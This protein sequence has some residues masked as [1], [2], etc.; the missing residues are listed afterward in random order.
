M[1]KL[2]VMFKLFGMSHWLLML[3]AIV[4]A[5]VLVFVMRSYNGTKIKTTGWILVGVMLLL[6]VL[7][8]VGRL[9][10]GGDLFESLPLEPINVFVFLCLFVQIKNNLTWIKFGYFISLPVSALGL[11]IVPNYLTSMGAWSL[12]GIAYFLNIGVLAGYV[13]LQLLWSEEYLSKKDILNCFVNYIIIISFIHILNVIF[14]FTTLGVHVNYM[15]TM[16][17]EYDVFNKWLYSIIK[18]PFLHQL[19]IW[20]I[21]FGLGFLLNIPFDIFKTNKDRQAQMEELVALGNLKAQQNYRKSRR[22]GGSHVLVNSADKAKPST[23]K[24]VVNK[25]SSG[26]VSVNKEVQVHKDDNK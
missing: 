26:F 3:L 18:I 1:D 12:G 25:S 11:F 4:I 2:C 7:E 13:I 23:P 5:I 22:S 20:A 19:P 6:V 15:G 10:G 24:N 16:G 14:R 8:F 9:I 21:I 17:E